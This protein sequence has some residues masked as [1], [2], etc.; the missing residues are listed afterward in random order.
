M[1]YV[2]VRR[3]LPAL[4]KIPIFRTDSQ[5]YIKQSV[6]QIPAKEDDLFAQCRSDTDQDFNFPLLTN[7]RWLFRIPVLG[8]TG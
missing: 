6:L 7:I 2:S 8:E 3:V 4:G 1:E 5:I